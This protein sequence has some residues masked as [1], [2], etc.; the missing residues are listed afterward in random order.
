MRAGSQEFARPAPFAPCRPQ[1]GQGFDHAQL[2]QLGILAVRDA[3][4]VKQ[5]HFGLGTVPTQRQHQLRAAPMQFGREPTLLTRR[6]LG[7]RVIEQRS[8]NSDS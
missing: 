7:Q 6:H 5:V 3:D 1:V 2:E 4:G 8:T